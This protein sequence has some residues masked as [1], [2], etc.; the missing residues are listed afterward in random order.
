MSGQLDPKSISVDEAGALAR[1][2]F[3]FG[4]PLVYIAVQADT[5]TNVAR[6]EGARAPLN[7]FAH[8]RQ[9]PDASDQVVVGLNVDTLYSLAVLDLSDGPLVLS[10]PEMGDRYW[11][12]QMIDAW[13]NVPHVP[14]TRTVGGKGG[15]FAIV[16]PG[17][18]RSLPAGAEDLRMPTNLA[19]IGGR[20]AL[21][22]PAEYDAVHAVQDRV[23][24]MPLEAWG[25]DW[26]PPDDV[27]VQPG[28]DAK[29]PV[30]RQV[31]AMTP[32]TFFARL[33]T[34]LVAN[35]PYEADAPEMERIARLGIGPGAEFPWASFDADLQQAIN[36]G[37]EAGNQAVHDQEAHLGDHV[38]GWQITLDMG[39][40][41]T[42]YAWLHARRM[43]GATAR[44]GVRRGRV[45]ASEEHGRPTP[46]PKDPRDLRQLLA[47]RFRAD[48]VHRPA[49][50]RPQVRRQPHARRPSCLAGLDARR[51]RPRR[52]HYRHQGAPRRSPRQSAASTSCSHCCAS[53]SSTG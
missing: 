52:G 13:N 44:P 38:N 10:V 29:T 19:L 47:E 5:A 49:Q 39:R 3:V 34:L 16:G 8:F 12:M 43:A 2:A 24:L 32:E 37:V 17:W 40:Y 9:L 35:P 50:R 36:E 25:T 30:P 11:L 28:V 27:P 6:P 46:R 18:T 33:N 4:L 53:G 31:L 22:G 1:E 41:G 14:G 7:Q 51:W 21:S 48:P 45:R 23:P 15:D 26:T 20:I 42:R